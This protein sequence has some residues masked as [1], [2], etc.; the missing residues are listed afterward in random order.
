MMDRRKNGREKGDGGQATGTECK[1]LSEHC[2]LCW[3]FRA[4]SSV[5]PGH[6]EMKRLTLP[7]ILTMLCCAATGPKVTGLSAQ[8][9]VAMDP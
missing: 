2:D 6:R 5:S 7:Q 4:L 9:L 1:T 3:L 8:G